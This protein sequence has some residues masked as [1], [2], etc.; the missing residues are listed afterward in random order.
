MEASRLAHAN[1]AHSS[2]GARCSED[3]EPCADEEFSEIC[4][5]S[6]RCASARQILRIGTLSLVL[7]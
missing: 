3:S 2:Q 1:I 4:S 5:N 6:V 7:S